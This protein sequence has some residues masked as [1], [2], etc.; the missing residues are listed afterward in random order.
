MRQHLPSILCYASAIL[1]SSVFYHFLFYAMIYILISQL[2]NG[3][4][5]SLACVWWIRGTHPT[6]WR[7]LLT[8][9]WCTPLSRIWWESIHDLR[10]LLNTVSRHL[11]SIT[12][13]QNPRW[14]ILIIL[15]WSKALIL[16]TWK[17]MLRRKK[18]FFQGHT[19]RPWVSQSPDAPTEPLHFTSPRRRHNWRETL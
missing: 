16:R 5:C 19:A 7:T 12:G 17:L 4:I 15:F 18:W 13:S 10:I 11:Q 3:L 1:C 8:D 6:L 2:T 14:S 9:R